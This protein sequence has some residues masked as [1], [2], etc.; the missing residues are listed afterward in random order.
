M[1]QRQQRTGKFQPID[2]LAACA[3]PPGEVATLRGHKIGDGKAEDGC[4]VQVACRLNYLDHEAGNDSMELAV[5]IV[6]RLARFPVALL[7]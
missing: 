7:A 1:E 4:A 5:L 6:K 3:V 2:G